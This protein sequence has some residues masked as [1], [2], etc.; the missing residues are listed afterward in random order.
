MKDMLEHLTILREQISRCEE[1][2]DAA[3]SDKKRAFF[4]R[5]VTSYKA[6]VTELEASI[7]KAAKG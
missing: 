1:L 2:R 5:I 7:S 4:E 6:L 3:K